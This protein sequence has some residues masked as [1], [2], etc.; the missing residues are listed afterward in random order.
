MT[1]ALSFLPSRRE[2]QSNSI[3]ARWGLSSHIWINKGFRAPASRAPRAAAN[4]CLSDY[5]RAG[6]LPQ[7]VLP[8]VVESY[9]GRV[10]IALY[11]RGTLQTPRVSKCPA[12]L[13]L[14]Q[15]LR[16]C[17]QILRQPHTYRPQLCTVGIFISGKLQVYSTRLVSRERGRGDR[18]AGGGGAHCHCWSLGS[19]SCFLVH[20]E[21]TTGT[22][23]LHVP[24][25][26]S[27]IEVCGC[28]HKE[29]TCLGPFWSLHILDMYW[30]LMRLGLQSCL[31]RLACGPPYPSL[32]HTHRGPITTHVSSA[33]ITSTCCHA[34]LFYLHGFWVPN[35]HPYVGTASHL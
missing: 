16:R 32:L 19:R 30:D 8:A 31:S 7:N 21:M 25:K 23:K 10:L 9:P 14:D 29:V 35:S 5:W 34:R 33:E 27:V 2:A 15:A 17:N 13:H 3:C 24:G 20:G 12:W 18:K 11:K 6:C 26:V 28:R 4:A 22:A 1:W